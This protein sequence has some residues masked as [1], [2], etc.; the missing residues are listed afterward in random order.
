[1]QP[2]MDIRKI[3]EYALSCEYEGKCFF[4]QSASRLSQAAAVNAFKPLVGEEQKHIDFIQHQ[5]DLLDRATWEHRFWREIGAGRLLFTAG[6]VRNY[7]PKSGGSHGARPASVTQGIPDQ[8]RFRRILR[9]QCSP[10]RGG[11]QA[12]IDAAF[13]VGMQIRAVVR[14]LLRPSF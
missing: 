11:S 5:I 4:E 3:Y 10:R 14:G 12:G 6:T 7:R 9:D 1:M 8:E 13:A 2:R